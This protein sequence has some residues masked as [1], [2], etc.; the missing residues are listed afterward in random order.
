MTHSL[1]MDQR[2]VELP[3]TASSGTLFVQTPQR[4]TDTPP[5]YY[6]LF[7]IDDEGVPS[8]GKIVRMNI[9]SAGSGDTVAPTQPQN[10]TLSRSN[11]NPRLKWS[12]STDQ[13]GVT[14]YAIHS[15][16]NGTL[17]AEIAR[18][19]GRDWTDTSAR[20]GTTYTYAVQAD[21]AAGNL[22]TPSALQRHR[23]LQ[24]ADHAHQLLDLSKQR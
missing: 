1:D 7:V 17:G 21:D 18:T 13:F 12:A 6:L 10:L 9:G 20:E 3:F 19:T 2:F 16:T 8:Q 5:G 15:S 11:G 22:S 24:G 14:G 4:A 23:C